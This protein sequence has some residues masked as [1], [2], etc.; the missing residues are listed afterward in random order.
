MW[1]IHYNF[2]WVT[3]CLLIFALI[4]YLLSYH[5]E[6][7]FL[8]GALLVA[9]IMFLVIGFAVRDGKIKDIAVE[10]SMEQV[11][12]AG[13]SADNPVSKEGS[14]YFTKATPGRLTENSLIRFVWRAKNGVTYPAEL[15]YALISTVRDPSKQVPTVSFRFKQP[16]PN[17]N[18][19][20]GFKANGCIYSEYTLKA[21]LS[22][23]VVRLSDKDWSQFVAE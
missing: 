16:D 4:A 7:E 11:S 1:W 17:D 21:N 8:A 22:K 10:K 3:V 23:V 19:L 5:D 20:E 15:P 9:G 13:L 2:V 12:T 6:L 18:F 14:S